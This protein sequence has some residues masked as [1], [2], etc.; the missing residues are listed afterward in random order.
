MIK[1][2]NCKCFKGNLKLTLIGLLLIVISGTI[3]SQKV[4]SLRDCIYYAL[5]NNIQVKQ[6]ELTSENN[7]INLLQSKLDLLPTVNGSLSHTYGWGRSIDFATYTYANQNTQ[8]S[9]FTFSSDLTIFNGLQKYNTIKQNQFEYLASKYDSDKMK[10]DISLN[11]AAAY[12]Q[13]L[14]YIEIVATAE[15]QVEITKLQIDRTE[16]LVNAGT[17]AKGSL[18][19]IQAQ[20]ATE[21]VNLIN[22]RNSLNL[23]YLD[24]LQLLDKSASEKLEIEK[25][26]LSITT[27]PELLP[28]EQ[29]YS[30]AILN[31]PEIKSAEYRL[32]SA[33]KG[34]SIAR[35]YRSPSLSLRGGWNTS[36]SDQIKYS[37][38]IEPNYG[39]II[40]FSNQFNDN[41]NKTLQVSL[42]IPIFNG[43][44][45]SSYISQSKLAAENAQYNLQLSKNQVRK[46][47]ETAFA[48]ALSAFKS[49]NANEKSLNAYTEAFKYMEQKF[50][51][52]LINALDYNV[53]KTQLTKAKSDLLSAKY[54]YI[55]KT[56]ILD[57]YMGKPITLEEYK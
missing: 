3:Y 41:Q 54:D 7:K 23:S 49:Y 18:F 9:Y 12:L 42:S 2:I 34:L 10:D 44:Q 8:Q 48:D 57:F 56:K 39:D 51:V 38:P 52:G 21:E 45:V 46:N 30:Y 43:F 37:N 55:F 26:E 22:A 24:L 1:I 29:I 33:N 19:D 14:F 16:K 50:D 53:A 31:L 15:D 6:S 40:P 13:I 28:P 5:D 35:G 11:I 20:G 47:V 27:V 17:L 32:Q 36:Y 4:W 25:P